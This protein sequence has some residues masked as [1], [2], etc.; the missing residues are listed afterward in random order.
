MDKQ[1]EAA[2]GRWLPFCMYS[3]LDDYREHIRF[4]VL[5]NDTFKH[6]GIGHATLHCAHGVCFCFYCDTTDF[7]Y[8]PKLY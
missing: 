5:R 1:G 6:M 3:R 2:G 8:F 7:D 4:A